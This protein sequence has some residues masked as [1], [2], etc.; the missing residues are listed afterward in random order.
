MR[1]RFLALVLFP[2]PTIISFGCSDRRDVDFQVVLFPDDAVRVNKTVAPS[3]SDPT[4]TLINDKT[5]FDET[6]V[7]LDGNS[8]IPDTDIEW[9][10]EAVILVQL[11]GDCLYSD[12]RSWW[13]FLVDQ[14]YIENGKL[15]LG[16]Y[17]PG[18][19]TCDSCAEPF[20]VISLQ[21]DDLEEDIVIKW[22]CRGC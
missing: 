4:A 13:P 17:D 10:D 21:R 18:R 3:P 15:H 22:I 2:L 8:L 20:V 12:C 16:L 11:E 6:L 9:D 1:F 14:V 5:A 19:M 7:D